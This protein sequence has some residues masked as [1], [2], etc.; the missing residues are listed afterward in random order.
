MSWLVVVAVILA[1]L[2][3]SADA[4]LRLK[5]VPEI[6][7]I[8]D[9]P[10]TLSVSPAAANPGAREVSFP[11]TD[12]LTLRGSVFSA[13]GAVR[14]LVLFCPEFNGNHWL[15]PRYCDALTEAGFAVL[16]FDVR[17]QG[18]SDAMPAYDP[19]HWISEFEIVDIRAAVRFIENDP[20][21][22][23]L[24]LGIFGVSRGGSAALG[25][26]AALPGIQAVLADSA[27]TIDGLASQFVRQWGAIYLP[28]IIINNIPDWHL[29]TLVRHAQRVSQRRHGCRYF[30][31]E[32]ML[33]S[34]ADRPVLLISGKRDSYVRP[35]I[36]KQLCQ[37][38][39]GSCESW[40]VPKAKHNK[41]RELAP[42]DYDQRI[43][44][45][46]ETHL[47]GSSSRAGTIPL[48]S[49]K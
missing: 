30:R 6:A 44:S 13:H 35:T 29:T 25:A 47:T 1:V 28:R 5:C 4:A 21:L 40:I 49:T 42:A 14:G 32:A 17:N 7:A 15:A 39:G 45:F 10:P 9:S 27:F 34:L 2:V 11:T 3:V 33:P 12:G 37:A 26:A 43:V 38:I 16:S 18:L 19:V 22:A 41:S 48:L 23:A 8:F 20:D 31:I 46:F 36:S 24:P